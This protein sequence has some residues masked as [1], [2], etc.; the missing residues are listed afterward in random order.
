MGA[1]GPA[2]VFVPN[3]AQASGGP[4]I[5]IGRRR[6]MILSPRVFD[7]FAKPIN[8]F[9]AGPADSRKIIVCPGKL[10]TLSDAYFF[11]NDRMR[12]AGQRHE[13]QSE[14]ASAR[15]AKTMPPRYCT[16]PTHG[17]GA[18]GTGCCNR[19]VPGGPGRNDSFSDQM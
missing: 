5:V 9:R 3:D 15:R 7:A 18:A 16:L 11:R 19:P 14:N 4:F 10:I 2:F 17:A 13:H 6:D 1:T 8:H 12:C